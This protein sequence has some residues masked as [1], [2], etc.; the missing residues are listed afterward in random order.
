MEEK[1]NEVMSD[2]D[3]MRRRTKQGVDSAVL[4]KSF[5][6]SGDDKQENNTPAQVS[7][8]NNVYSYLPFYSAT[9]QG[10]T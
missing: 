8:V 5:E 1:E 10:P 7:L 6:R 3:W 9:L 2:F 4:E